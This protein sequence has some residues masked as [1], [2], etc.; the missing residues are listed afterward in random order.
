M[1]KCG[2]MALRH[3]ETSLHRLLQSRLLRHPDGRLWVLRAI[4][5][6]KTSLYRLRPSRFIRSQ[7]YRK[8]VRTAFDTLK[9]HFIDFN[10]LFSRRPEDSLCALSSIR[11][12]KPSFKWL[13]QNTFFWF[14]GCRKWFRM[15]FRHLETSFHRLRKSRFLRRSESTLWVLRA[16][17]LLKTL[18]KRLHESLF[19]RFTGCRK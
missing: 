7:G 18:L 16:I 15:A 2:R 3:L 17:R 19:L 12:L 4:H 14:P 9:H 5:L 1:Q 8:L 6:F 11:L 13:Y 10:S